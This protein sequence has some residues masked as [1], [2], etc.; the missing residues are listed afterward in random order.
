MSLERRP[1]YRVD[2]A[3]DGIEAIEKISVEPPD[4]ILVDLMMPRLDGFGLIDRLKSDP[5]TKFIPIIILTSK[6]ELADKLKGIEIGAND[7]ITKP[8]DP[9]ELLARVRA[10]A[11]IKNLERELGVRRG[12]EAA[13]QMGRALE[14]EISDPLTGIVGNVEMLRAWR[15]LDETEIDISIE[16][17]LTLS[18]RAQSI[19]REMARLSK[20]AS[21]QCL[22]G[23]AMVDRE[24]STWEESD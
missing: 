8:F 4:L 15:E 20:I 11:R 21:T 12:L 1:D 23:S 14:H 5:K 6:I 22:P 7:Y 9:S 10:Q 13:A 18:H 24:N 3:C 17:I 19:A 2:E 16:E